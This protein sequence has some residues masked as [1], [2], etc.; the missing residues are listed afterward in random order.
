[1]FFI[2]VDDSN[3]GTDYA[4]ARRIIDL[5]TK[6]EESVKRTYVKEEVASYCY[7]HQGL[8]QL[9]GQGH[10]RLCQEFLEDHSEAAGEH[11]K[12]EQDSYPP[13]LLRGGDC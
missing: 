4:I 6:L 11:V 2:L 7:R 9:H 10:W 3:E 8:I 1:M 5:N 12:A 13:E